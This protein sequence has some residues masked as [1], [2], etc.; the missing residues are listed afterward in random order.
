[1]WTMG[2]TFGCPSR[3]VNF[4]AGIRTINLVSPFRRVHFSKNRALYRFKR[5]L[6]RIASVAAPSNMEP[7][8]IAT[9]TW[10]LDAATMSKIF[11]VACS[12]AIMAAVSRTSFSMLA[13]PIQKQFSLSLADMGLIQSSLLFGYILGQVRFYTHD[14][15]LKLH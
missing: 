13:I 7:P 14:C 3:F 4:S 10:H 11:L 9:P 15:T 1:M 5:D 12:A 2:A 6:N 8:A